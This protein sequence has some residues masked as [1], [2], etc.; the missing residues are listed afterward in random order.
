MNEL[1]LEEEALQVYPNPAEDALYI[2]VVGQSQFMVSIYDLQ[3][4]LKMQRSLPADGGQPLDV[5]GLM[6]GVY[7]LRV[8]GDGLAYAGRFVKL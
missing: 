1:P 5:R 3:G 4:R 7:A 6:P 8:V 2:H